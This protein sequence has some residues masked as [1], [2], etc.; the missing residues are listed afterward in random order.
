MRACGTFQIPANHPALP[1]HFPGTPIVPGVVL[2]DEMLHLIESQRHA[3]AVPTSGAQRPIEG[4]AT[5]GR[6]HIGSV[7]FHRLVLPEQPLTLECAA[8]TAGALRFELRF[9]GALVVSG[10]LQQRITTAQSQAVI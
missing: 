9:E 8:E 4:E 1:G 2:L 10:T 3:A 7:K 6:W 5:A